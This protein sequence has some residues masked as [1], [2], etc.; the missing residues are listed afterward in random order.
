MTQDTIKALSDKELLQVMAW[1]ELEQRDRAARR[2]QETIA[3]IRRL[4]AGAGVSIA[5]EGTKG[6]PKKAALKPSSLRYT[7]NKTVNAG[8]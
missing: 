3:Q 8:R 6:R 1:G 7:P 2:K 5:I 4:A